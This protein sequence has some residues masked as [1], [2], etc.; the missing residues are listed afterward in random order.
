MAVNRREMAETADDVWDV[1]CDGFTY[2]DWVVGTRK[3]RDVDDAFPTIGSKLHYTIGHRP[4]RHDSHTEVLDIDH[5]SRCIELAIHSQPAGRFRVKI[6]ITPRASSSRALVE[7]TEHPLDGVLAV[8][9][10]PLFDLLIK[11][12]NVETLRRL[13]RVT[14]RHPASIGP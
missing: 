9:H 3:I 14:Q 6:T 4:F 13:E 10:N 2:A 8:F 7:L 11:A 1:I 5:A 12:R